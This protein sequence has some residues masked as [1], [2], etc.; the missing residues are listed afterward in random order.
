MQ[1]YKYTR[2]IV[3][4]QHCEDLSLVPKGLFNQRNANPPQHW[5]IEGMH[6]SA[7]K[8]TAPTWIAEVSGDVRYS[9]LASILACNEQISWYSD[10]TKNHGHFSTHTMMSV[11]ARIGDHTIQMMTMPLP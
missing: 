11:A 10:I 2:G 1:L 7:A 6:V 8:D 3:S 5:S 9:R 4:G